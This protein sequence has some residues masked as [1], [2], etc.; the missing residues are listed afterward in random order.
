[1]NRIAF[2]FYENSSM[3]KILKFCVRCSWRNEC[4]LQGAS[5]AKEVIFILYKFK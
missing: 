4:V 5:I 2:I 1:M 3:K